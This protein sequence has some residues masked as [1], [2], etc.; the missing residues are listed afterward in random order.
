MTRTLL[1]PLELLLRFTPRRWAAVLTGLTAAGV[2]VGWVAV[3]SVCDE[4]C[5][6]V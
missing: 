5:D 2:V 6:H 4:D 1:M 3:S